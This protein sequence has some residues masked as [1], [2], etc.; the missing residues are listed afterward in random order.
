[1]ST[2][3]EDLALLT[4]MI[5]DAELAQLRSEAQRVAAQRERV[6]ALVKQR[7]A[8]AETL[9]FRG[10][11]EDLALTVG[12]DALWQKWLKREQARFNAELARSAARYEEQHLQATRAFGRVAAVNQLRARSAETR[13]LILARRSMTSQ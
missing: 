6:R 13:R 9:H 8:R 5:L 10:V 2:D 12:Q 11:L 1:M 3:L 7:E 4:E